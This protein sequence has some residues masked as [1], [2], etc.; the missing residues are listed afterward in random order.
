MPFHPLQD[1]KSDHSQLADLGLLVIRLLTAATF[2]Y[3]Q[4]VHHLQLA[5][6]HLW[7]GSEWNLVSQ[8]TERGFPLPSIL[9]ASAIGL[10][11]ANLL[12]FL[13]GFFT[14]FNSLLLALMTVVV[15][16]SAIS[17]SPPLN[18]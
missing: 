17:L 5:L 12:G 9:A 16:L 11:A 2:A 15:L 10:F 4:L 18:P 14:R 8:F 1:S 6:A 3:Y 7:D 13:L